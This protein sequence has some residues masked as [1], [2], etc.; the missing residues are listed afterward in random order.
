MKKILFAGCLLLLMVNN[1]AAHPNE[2]LNMNA[3]YATGVAVG[4]GIGTGLF[5]RKY[6]ERNYVQLVGAY[7]YGDQPVSNLGISIGRY[8]YQ[9]KI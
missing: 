9:E 7:S 6:F 8:F 3:D 5:I 2:T 4:E 1:A